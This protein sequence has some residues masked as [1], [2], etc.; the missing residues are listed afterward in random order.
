MLMLFVSTL[1]SVVISWRAL[2]ELISIIMCSFCGV[3]RH[4]VRSTDLGSYLGGLWSRRGDGMRTMLLEQCGFHRVCIAQTCNL[5]T[6][7]RKAPSSFRCEFF[8]FR[9]EYLIGVAGTRTMFGS[10]CVAFNVIA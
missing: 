7:G 9:G 3:A 6:L 1:S 10:G 5:P 2:S 4:S 8:Y